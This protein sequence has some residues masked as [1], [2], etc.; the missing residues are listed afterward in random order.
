MIAPSGAEQRRRLLA[1]WPKSALLMICSA[2]ILWA[3]LIFPAT[4]D[5]K[6][7][8]LLFDERPGLPGMAAV[9]AGFQNAL[10]SHLRDRLEVYHE[11]MDLS[12]FGTTDYR[13]R[14]RDFLQAKY[15]DK[16]ID[17]AVAVMGPALDF[18]LDN[19]EAIF[20]GAP[21]VFCGVDKRE[22]AGRSLPPHVSGIFLRRMFKP[23]V[24]LALQLH[25]DVR[26][27]A[28]VSGKSQFDARVL[29]AARKEWREYE[30]RFAFRYLT[31]LPM[32][33]LLAELARLPSQTVVLFT[34]FFQDA[35]GE[36]FVPYDVVARASAAANAPVYGFMD[37]YLGHGIVGGSLYSMDEQGPAAAKLA[38]E[39]LSNTNP[40]PASLL[41]P[42]LNQLLFDWRQLH[43]W[44]I[45]EKKLPVGSQIR[46]RPSGVWEQHRTFVIAVSGVLASL[47]AILGALLFQISRRK[48]AEVSLRQSEERLKVSAASMNTG[49]WQY[50]LS[51]CDLWVTE[52]S[53][54]MFGLTAKTEL[55]PQ[56]FLRAVHQDDRSIVAAAIR[57]VRHGAS[58]VKS[59]EFRI[60][61]PDGLTRWILAASKIHLDSEGRPQNVSGVFRD[62][63]ARKTAE[64]EAEQ[65]SER[66][67]AIQDEERQQI[68][69]EL[70]DSTTQHLA[71][72]IL[73]MMS[74]QGR[75]SSDPKTRELCID[76][77][78]SLEEAAK[79]LRAYVYL[80]NPPQL[81]KDGLSAALQR[82]VDGF[83][84]RTGIASK[85]RISPA[86]DGRLPLTAQRALLRIVQ[87]GL[88]NVHRHADASRVSVDLK[89][90]RDQV[91]LLVVD[92]G[93]GM[94][95]A[96]NGHV[97]DTPRAGVGIPGMKARLRRLGG[98]LKILSRRGGTKLHAVIP[99]REKTATPTA[100][101]TSAEPRAWH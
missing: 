79:E 82:Y 40:T 73:N 35:T 13:T 10:T 31:G 30:D 87:E 15:A 51:T 1:V 75:L 25:P 95:V 71:A 3:A 8:V 6:R 78:R 36:P 50:N 91:H 64:H 89:F 28:V 27:I 43:R 42:D 2:L 38:F 52:Q 56:T 72:A 58:D 53:R 16:K 24:E 69:L 33:E 65:L 57:S 47:T 81:T 29:E 98:D 74:I 4:A 45:N 9:E 20:P 19:A 48:T 62:I 55:K 97:C 54:A 46:F 5:T 61:H 80:L 14:L 7:V 77:E 93:K 41:D 88:A 86:V 18:L 17:L 49:L 99:V 12:R 22:I 92:D 39:I 84:R 32:P 23:T 66:L 76:V 94:A 37:Q 67:L 11:G 96:P 85:L 21:I 90:V 63:T 68:A 26:H 70:H 83:S 101:F 100:E 60:R 34:T 59:V 44:N